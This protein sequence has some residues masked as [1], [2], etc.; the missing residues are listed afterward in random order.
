MTRTVAWICFVVA[1]SAARVVAQ[2]PVLREDEQFQGR[3]AWVIENG[4]IRVSLLR[5]GGHIAEVRLISDDPRRGLNPMYVSPGS[6]YVGHI[7][8]FPHFGPASPEERQHGL[9]GHGEAAWVEWRQSQPPR[10]DDQ[11]L[12]FFYGA[13]LPQTHYRIERAVSLRRG[14]AAVRVEETVENLA[15]YDR[16]YNRNQHATFGAP[17]VAAAKNV[18]DVGGTKAIS[19]PRRTGGGQWAANREFDWPLAP[20]LSGTVSLREF[21]AVPEGQV[22]TAI[23]TAGGA[24]GW[25]TL[26]NTAYPLL[27]GY[28]FPADQHRWIIDWQ[29]QP[30]PGG[31]AATARGIEFG[32]SPFD[33]G[34]R[35]SVERGSLLGAP[36][37]AWIGARQRVSSTFTIFVTEV[38]DGFA[39]VRSVRRE[40]S[41]IVISE[42]GSAREL[43]IVHTQ[44]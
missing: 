5:S 22:Y 15:L 10:R 21:R 33:E 44:N 16:P 20:A 29:N 30:K 8:C 27:V 31:S 38:P 34:L 14:E 3:K 26:Y 11:R 42:R 12:T 23:L 36:T 37:Y 1:L 13:H 24:A 41:R 19:D 18:L 7:V 9:R 39:G 28:L 43:T 40:D 2:A 32:T 6:G 4:T 25:F 17:F 35:R